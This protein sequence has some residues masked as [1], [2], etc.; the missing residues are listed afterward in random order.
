MAMTEP[1]RNSVLMYPRSWEPL[2]KSSPMSTRA[3]LS[4]VLIRGVMIAP[5]SVQIISFLRSESE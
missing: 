2:P 5:A 4:M 3:R 1:R